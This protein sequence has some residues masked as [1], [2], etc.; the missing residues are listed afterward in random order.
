MSDETEDNYTA[1]T[2]DQ[3]CV[4]I[5]EGRK[6]SRWRRGK[7]ITKI[8]SEEHHQREIIQ[9]MKLGNYLISVDETLKLVVWDVKEIKNVEYLK[10]FSLKS[11]SESKVKVLFHPATYINKILIGFEDG[12]M[13]LWNLLSEK[14]IYTFKGWGKEITEIVQ[15]PALDVVGI[16]LS[17]GEIVIHNL[18]FD[19]SLMLFQSESC[20]NSLSFRTDGFPFLVSA[21]S[22]G[23]INIWDLDNQK[24][25][26]NIK[27]IHQNGVSCVSFLNKEPVL[28][29]TGGD[30]SLKIWIFDSEVKKKKNSKKKN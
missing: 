9:L 20:I 23:E 11:E 29:S 1:F 8:E 26:A 28:V 4:Y 21:H 27:H 24:L 14:L 13:Q 19:K 2:R 3:D 10:S 22:N 25:H 16:G 15:S 30:N 7:M 6:L 18:K 5:A 17:N 12:K